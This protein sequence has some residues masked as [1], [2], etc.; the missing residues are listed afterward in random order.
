MFDLTSELE[1]GTALAAPYGGRVSVTCQLLSW[2][3]DFACCSR[4]NGL[5]TSWAI[6][7]L[8]CSVQKRMLSGLKKSF[9]VMLQC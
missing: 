6:G 4:E 5:P 3:A 8:G 1:N 7:F 9:L 2:E